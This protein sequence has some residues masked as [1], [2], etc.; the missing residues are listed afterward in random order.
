M[1]STNKTLYIP[2][3]GKSL[4]SRK[5]IL[6]HDP[7]AEEIW[8]KE[9]FPLNGKAKSKWLAY[10]M[11][12]RAWS[13]D[14]WTRQQL[15]AMPSAAVLHLGCGL[16]ARSVR[17]NAPVP[18]YDVDMPEVIA[19]RKQYYQ[20]TDLY[21]MIASAVTQL[22]GLDALPQG[23][24]AVV[25]MEGLSMYLPLE[26][27]RRLFG[28]LQARFDRLAIILD[29]YTQLAVRTS[30]FKNPI[31]SV[32]ASVVTGIDDPGVLT[33][34]GRLAFSGQLSLTP[35]EEL[36]QLKGFEGWF[37]RRMFA[38]RATGHLYRLYTYRSSNF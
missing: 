1:N 29:A 16:D 31:R 20:E 35:E 17:V 2:L 24:G 21:R 27:L 5:G 34:P 23:G 9:S 33:L 10:F 6:L 22:S 15:T 25:V 12:M 32:G 14:R 38:G 18:W 4:V 26:D 11:G 37:F 3:Y 30:S 8:A 36:S 28:A 7:K 19:V 13:M